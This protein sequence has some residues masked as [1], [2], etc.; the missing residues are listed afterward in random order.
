MAD[1][2]EAL[3]GRLVVVPSNPVG[4]DPQGNV[5]RLLPKEQSSGQVVTGV[6]A[7]GRALGHGVRN[8]VSSISSSPPPTGRAIRRSCST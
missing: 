3:T 1:L 8:H 7:V 2:A 4:L 6:V 5:I